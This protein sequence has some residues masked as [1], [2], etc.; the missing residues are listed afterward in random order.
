[1]ADDGTPY[2]IT[3]T[4]GPAEIFKPTAPLR[5]KNARGCR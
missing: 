5:T 4:P 3:K 2:I 1:M